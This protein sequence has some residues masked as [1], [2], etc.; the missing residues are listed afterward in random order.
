[1]VIGIDIGTGRLKLG[2]IDP[3]GVAAMVPNARG[4]MF[5]PSAVYIPTS[6]P[7]LVGTDAIEQGFL[8][9]DGYIGAFKLKLGTTD[10]LLE[11]APVTATDAAAISIA[12]LKEDAE[13]HLGIQVDEAVITHPANWRNDQQQALVEA[14]DRSGITVIRQVPEPTAA[15]FAYA[16]DKTGGETV[17]AVYD[18]GAGT[19]D[20]SVLKVDGARVEVLA[21]EGV[22]QLGGNDF[23]A[24]LSEQV[25]AAIERQCGQRPGD[26][27]DDRLTRLDI[28]RRVE[29]AKFSLGKQAQVPIVVSYAGQQVIVKVEQAEFHTAIQPLVRRSIEALQAAIQ[30]AGLTND[31]IDRLILVGGGSRQPYIQSCVADATSMRPATDID[32]DKAVVFGAAWAGVAELKRQ[33]RSASLRGQVIPAPAAFVQEVTAHAVGCAVLER[34]NQGRRMTLSEIVPKHTRI[35]CAKTDRF[36]LESESQT[37]A[38]IEIL[39]GVAGAEYDDCLSIGELLL[40]GLPTESTRSQRI[41]V[42]YEIDADGMI[43]ATATDAVS[44]KRETVS[45]DY[46]RGITDRR[47]DAA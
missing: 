5:T 30:A 23:D 11:R 40:D 17:I 29:T 39:Q 6:G 37:Q 31:Q 35:P 1:M 38:K 15:G 10:S 41:E 18:L 20:A 4:E 13:R 45:V 9:P 34:S 3:S 47:K 28:Q 21:T 36:F 8:D 2:Y 19:F 22:P 32:P 42:R 16:L 33:G 26:G 46:K 24:I 25:Y 43:T 12:Q 27:P 7:P 14:F 44:G